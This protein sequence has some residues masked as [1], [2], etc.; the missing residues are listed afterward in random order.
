MKN[1]KITSKTSRRLTNL[2]V[3]LLRWISHLE[4]SGGHGGEQ[5]IGQL[6]PEPAL[7][8]PFNG[9]ETMN[10][11]YINN[12]KM[13][14]KHQMLKWLALLFVL[15]ASTTGVWAQTSTSLTQTV[16]PGIEPYLV[17]PGDPAN[18]FTWTITPGTSGVDWTIIPG[19]QPYE[20]TVN[21]A[22][23]A[24]SKTFTLTLTEDDVNGCLNE[25]SVDVTVNPAPLPPTASDQT[26]CEQTPIQTLT[27]T[28]TVPVGSTV[29]WYDAATG[30]NVVASPTLNTVGTVTYYAESDVTAG[31]CTS[32][33]RTAVTLTIEA[34]PLPPT[35][36]DQTECE[37][38]PIQTLTAT[39]TVP[40]GS[41]V[42]WYD[43]ATGGNVVASPTLNTVG[44][45]TY[46]AESDVTA[47]GCTSLTRTAVTLT[48]EAAPLPP[49]ASDQTECEQTPIQTLTATATVP[50]GSTVVWYDAAT[51]GNV[52]AS[53]TLNT[54]G[55]VTY[56]AESDVTAGGCTSLTRTAVTLTIEAA[57]LPPTASD[58]TECEQTPIQTLTATATVPVGSTVV[59]YDAATGGN[60]VASPTL[61][62]VGTVTYYAESDVTAGGCTSLTR[63]AVTLTIEAAPLPPT[64][65]DQTECEQTPIQTLT[66]T[67]TV[68]VGSTV[69]WYD[70]AT[71]GN[72][73]AS[74]TLNTVGT[75]TYYAESDVTAG[76]CTSLTRTAVT[77]TIEAAPLPPTASD[78][79]ECEQTPIQTLTAT[80]T[81]P[82]G[83]TVVWYD[84]ATGGNVVA[85]PTLNT[86]GTVTYYAESDVT[87]GGCTSL[88]RTAVTL[89]IEAAPLPPTASDQT[90][91][92]Q[93]PIQTLTATAT[94]PVGSTVVWYDAATGGNVVASP[95]LNTVGTV[96]Y[97]AESDVTAGGCT[98]LT[99]TAVT[100]TIEAA[101]L[102]PTASDQTECEQTPIQTLTATATV[103]VGSTV[104]WYDAA[105]GGNVVASPTLNTVGTVT[106]YAESDVTAGG[107]T[108]LTR[109]AVTLTIEAA[110]LPPTASDQTE[111][112]QTPI[113]TLTATATVPV[114]ST[115]VWYD[116]A[117]GGNVVASPTLNTVGT[118]TYYAESD[119]TAGGCTSLTRTAVTLTI[120]AAPLPPTASDQTECEQ[121]P[122]QTL[123]A[124]AT[125]PVGSTV[126]WYDAA[127]GGNVV[128]SPTLN[129]VGTVTYY[130]ESDVTAGGCTSLTRT[131]VTLTIEAAPLPPTASDQTEC[132]QTPI[133][134]LTATAT[135]PVGSTV[136]WY[137]AATGGNVVA[138]PT[139]NTVGT[140]TYYA[141]SD[142]T[143]GGC[144]SLT[145]TAVTLTIEA[146]PLPPT[147]SDQTECEQTPIQTLTAT[148]TVPVGST[149][150]WYDAATGGNVV[151]S[152]TL[153]TVGTVTYYAES[154]VTAG[155]CTSLTRTAV[156]LTIEA[157]PLPPTASDQTECEQTP[158]QTLTATAT[159]PV[160]STVVW[161]DAATG[162]NVVAS[163]TLNT[164]GT[165]TYY[166]ESDV[167]A[168][169]CT[170]LTR[171]AVT[172]TIEAAPLPTF[173]SCNGDICAEDPSITYT[174]QSGMS[175]Y[176][177]TVSAGGTIISGGGTN[178][179][180]IT[181]SWTTAGTKTVTVNYTN[182]NGC[183]GLTPANCTFNVNAKPATSP[184]FHN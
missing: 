112:E 128:A 153:N 51:G 171:T 94:V 36:S 162:G 33:T 174:T 71:G 69:V 5:D 62:T 151:A 120:E 83:S 39:A 163:P 96:T 140:V 169:G 148:A 42:V 84:A 31:G 28:A 43:A 9:N 89:T 40:V 19:A 92:E 97:Y 59:W 178:D 170:S 139:L 115:V 102:P 173:L 75:V 47:G 107:C 129:T 32:L 150:V 157:A 123:T 124:T 64:A 152:P 45:V 121:T 58:Q 134:T 74:P 11:K 66:A 159:V 50:V 165:V 15:V 149:V 56:Y 27:A 37:Q 93:T 141:E 21:W 3:Q 4:L 100:L 109:T 130:A 65:S 70:A 76:G 108:S 136:V 156:T 117:T 98:S 24:T 166:A 155:G 184:I 22:D 60:V 8:E 18:N 95:T 80:A 103:P 175:N 30:G 131:A 25:V 104:V 180:S 114:G 91:C 12:N 52:V 10:Y 48:I 34:A 181:I 145:R 158:I 55:T 168:G 29:V 26:E 81:V 135:V 72:V 54:V 79:T 172:L 78:Q 67:A 142:V 41:T 68:P 88:T 14:T 73:V 61:N 17:I 49:T 13:K 111:C 160:G 127:T 1:E 126:V 2:I 122:I 118:V 6:L 85:S 116:A 143:A 38:T 113:Q 44:T 147:A 86:V 182:V 154:D 161:Y 7:A 90:E 125:V 82:V 106:Y 99:R 167:T 63:T 110:P 23:P 77:L 137:D 53:P 146:A 87:A 177:W 183:P 16:C 132:E 164:V 57:P 179:D 176:I 144:T 101:P 133:Q 35:A 119:V 46:Y 138:S 20:I 105:T